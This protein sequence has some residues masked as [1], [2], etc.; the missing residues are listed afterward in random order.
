MTTQSNQKNKANKQKQKNKNS[1]QQKCLTQA[2]PV[3]ALSAINPV[4]V[5][6]LPVSPN[7]LSELQNKEDIKNEKGVKN[8]P[9]GCL[10]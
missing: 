7:N 3:P 6:L 4:I 1:Q 10:K 5:Y 9:S 2:S 8:P